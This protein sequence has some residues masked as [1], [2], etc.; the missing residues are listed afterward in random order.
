MFKYS[1]RLEPCSQEGRALGRVVFG[2]V[3]IAGITILAERLVA[4]RHDVD[5][6]KVIAGTWTVA[7]GAGGIVSLLAGPSDRSVSPRLRVLSYVVPT[8]G[9]A[10]LLPLTIHLP[11]ALALGV[12]VAAFDRWAFVSACITGVTHVV[13]ATLAALRAW[14]LAT[15]RPAISATQVY[16]A[17]LAVSCVPFAIVYFI[18]PVVVGLTGLPI[19]VLLERMPRFIQSGGALPLAV[20]RA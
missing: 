9:I 19:L 8:F 7:F 5:A 1:E 16:V 2:L 17:V 14:Q 12:D 18:P 13:F 3:L 4:N 11:I 6:A 15:G 20:V 10:L